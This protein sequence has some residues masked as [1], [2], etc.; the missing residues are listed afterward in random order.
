M[1]QLILTAAGSAAASA[2]KAGLGTLL[3]RTVASTAAA[4]AAGAAERLIFGPRKRTVEGPRLES[5]QIQSSTEGAG[6][7]RVY[8][9]ARLAGQLIWAAQFRETL[10]ETT[11]SSGGKGGRL[12]ASKTTAHA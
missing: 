1:A 6:I 8:G 2:G 10:A 12:A 5:F 7:P 3:A 11:E 4:Y 9:R